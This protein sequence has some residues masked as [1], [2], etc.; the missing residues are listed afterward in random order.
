MRWGLLH[1]KYIFSQSNAMPSSK[2]SR[3][4]TGT[5]KWSESVNDGIVMVCQS[6]IEFCSSLNK[7]WYTVPLACASKIMCEFMNHTFKTWNM[8]SEVIVISSNAELL[9]KNKMLQ[10]KPIN[11]QHWVRLWTLPFWMEHMVPDLCCLIFRCLKQW[12]AQGMNYL[13]GS[14]SDNN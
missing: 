10:P 14:F 3:I 12:S 6:L 4:C 13:I 9:Q 8:V 1:V 5:N 2:K 11:L 7:Y